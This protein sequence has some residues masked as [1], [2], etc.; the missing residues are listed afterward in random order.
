MSDIQLLS[1]PSVQ[2]F[3]ANII[4]LIVDEMLP[5][6]VCGEIRDWIKRVSKSHYEVI[7]KIE[8]CC[9]KNNLTEQIGS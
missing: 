6:V 1:E 8:L 4:Q 5:K 9:L 7:T 3:K 2:T